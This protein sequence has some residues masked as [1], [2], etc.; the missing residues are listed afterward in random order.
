MTN[1]AQTIMLVDD[2]NIDNYVNEHVITNH[3][4]SS[5]VVKFDAARDGLN[6]LASL[7]NNQYEIP[8]LILLD[9]NMPD[10]DGFGFLE[11]FGSLP[12]EVTAHTR[13]SMLS[14]SKNP[15]DIKQSTRYQYVVKYFEKPLTDSK[16]DSVLSLLSA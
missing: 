3:L 14:S 10:I 16:L 1:K 13:I 8:D 11:E 4:P 6:Y 12:N 2:N 9:I 7:A 15:D 5:K